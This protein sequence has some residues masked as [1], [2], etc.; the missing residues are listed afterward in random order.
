LG[1]FS[2]QETI[3]TVSKDVFQ[4][5]II[6][7]QVSRNTEELYTITWFNLSLSK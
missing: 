7:I 2:Y 4:I 3:D 6:F 1:M 5:K